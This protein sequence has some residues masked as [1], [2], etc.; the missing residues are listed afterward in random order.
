MLRTGGNEGQLPDRAFYKY[1]TACHRAVS[2]T[3]IDPFRVAANDIARSS[4]DAEREIGISGVMI[5]D[6]GW[7]LRA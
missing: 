1:R 4:V 6:D 7:L 3:T 5:E 2:A